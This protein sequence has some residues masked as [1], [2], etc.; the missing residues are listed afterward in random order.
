M[1]KKIRLYFSFAAVALRAQ[2][3]HRGAFWAGFV[4]QFLSH[5]ARF[6][7]IYFMVRAFDSVGGWNADQVL[8]FYG[9]N[10]LA[11]A[12]ASSVFFFPAKNLNRK[13]RTG[14]FDAS[15]TKPMNPLAHEVFLGFNPGYICHFTLSITA[16]ALS[17]RGAGFEVS[18][19]PLLIVLLLGAALVYGAMYVFQSAGAFRFI[20]SNPLA[21][22]MGIGRDFVEY[23]ISIYHRVIQGILTFALPFAFMSFYPVAAALGIADAGAFPAWLGYLTPAAGAGLLFLSVTLWNRVSR[24]YKSTGT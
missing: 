10:M 21:L 12:L 23:P 1:G 3:I 18:R 19:L 24:C 7:S 13:I 20:Y 15:L 16:M 9:F 8:F 17:A 22:L 6:A 4:G 11:Y 5:G 14:E 2:M